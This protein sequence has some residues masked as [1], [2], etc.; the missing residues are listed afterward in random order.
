MKIIKYLK[1][2]PIFILLLF[3][4]CSS[5]KTEQVNKDSLPG[6]GT[7][8]FTMLDTND[9]KLAEGT[10]KITEIK[11]NKIKGTYEF[12][13]VY[14]EF[15]GYS[16]MKS[17]FEGIINPSSRTLLI[18]TNPGTA[19]DNVFFDLKIG[20][21]SL[22]GIWYYSAFRTQDIKGKISLFKNHN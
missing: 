13:K 17:I 11:E 1:E 16:S 4:G 2:L 7:Y 12:D 8:S 10:L 22:T 15:Q 14:S 5:G 19:D 6:K 18:D 3:Y 20:K 21:D 9:I